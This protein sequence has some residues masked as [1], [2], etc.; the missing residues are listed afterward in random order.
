MQKSPKPILEI[1]DFHIF[2]ATNLCPKLSPFTV[3]LQA[4][5]ATRLYVGNRQVV[6]I[7]GP[8]GLLCV[9][10]CVCLYLYMYICACVCVWYI[11]IYIYVCV[12]VYVHLSI[13]IYTHIYIYK[14]VCVCVRSMIYD[15]FHI[16]GHM[17]RLITYLC[18]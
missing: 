3:H 7:V 6:E 1:G 17:H 16:Q 8:R 15:V 2:H 4:P 5:S 18:N 12:C 9:C 11:Y 14:Y 10:G 13:Y